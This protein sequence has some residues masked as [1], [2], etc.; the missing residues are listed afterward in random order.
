M[1]SKKSTALLGGRKP[2]QVFIK[3]GALIHPGMSESS[4]IYCAKVTVEGKNGKSKTIDLV[5][6]RFKPRKRVKFMSPNFRHPKHQLKAV[7]ELMRINRE[8]KLGLNIIPTVRLREN[9]KNPSSLL[10]TRLNA[11]KYASLTDAEKNEI[12]RQERRALR[13]LKKIG[14]SADQ[15]FFII[16]KNPATGRVTSWIADFGNLYK[17]VALKK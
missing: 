16:E 6:K 5:E 10:L 8:Q 13:T 14:F 17:K 12:N 9:S 4:G 11:V 7:Q 3:R 2:R 15:D 1:I